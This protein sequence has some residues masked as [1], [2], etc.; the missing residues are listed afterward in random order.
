MVVLTFNSKTRVQ[1]GSMIGAWRY[2]FG[3]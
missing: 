1:A 2:V 3:C